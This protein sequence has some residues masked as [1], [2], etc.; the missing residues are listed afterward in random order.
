MFQEIRPLVAPDGRDVTGPDFVRQLANRAGFFRLP[1]LVVAGHSEPDGAPPRATFE[2]GKPTQDKPR[3]LETPANH[4]RMKYHSPYR[5]Q[6]RMMSSMQI[7]R[8]GGRRR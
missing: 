3:C 8:K 5:T 1:S 6:R 7:G 4:V 2:L